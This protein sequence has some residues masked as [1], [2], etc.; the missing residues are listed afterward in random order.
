M[1][2]APEAFATSRSLTRTRTRSRG[3]GGALLVLSARLGETTTVVGTGGMAS[4]SADAAVP[5]A[6]PHE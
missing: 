2:T 6:P 3:S 1:S 5:D 4:V